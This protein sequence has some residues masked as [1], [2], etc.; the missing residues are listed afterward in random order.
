MEASAGLVAGSHNR[1]EL[2]VIHGHEEVKTLSINEIFAMEL[3][4]LIRLLISTVFFFFLQPK[5]LRNLDGQVC[6]IC[7]DEVGVTVDGDL[8]V[9]CNECG[10]PVCRPC[11]EYERREG[12]QNCPQC[13]TRYR[14]LKGSPRVEG[15]EDE[16]GVDDI[17]QE[18]KIDDQNK[19]NEHIVDAMLH[20]KMSYGRGPEDDD[21]AQ[22]PVPV[23]AGGRSR[24]VCMCV[25]FMYMHHLCT[26]SF[27]DANIYKFF[28]QYI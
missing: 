26:Q 28:G 2:V 5:T 6:E 7:G 17:E 22:F 18:F 27:Y 20:G 25:L 10:F 14:R 1:N 3:D 11:Y 16:E 4:F 21:N 15:D 12:S 24:P 13:K 8:F 23:I 19:K 9:A